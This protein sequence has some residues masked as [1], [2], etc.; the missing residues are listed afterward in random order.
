MLRRFLAAIGLSAI[1]AGSASAKPPYAPYPEGAAANDVYNLLSATT[2]AL[3][4]RRQE[5]LPLPGK[6]QPPNLRTRR[7]S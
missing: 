6:S 1:A 4:G 7:R 3:L 5:K 2:R